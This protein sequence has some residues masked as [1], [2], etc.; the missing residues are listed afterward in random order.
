MFAAPPA[1]T[2]PVATADA[3]PAREMPALKRFLRDNLYQHY[4]VQRMSTK[5]RRIV[6]ELFGA[7]MSDPRLLPS[8]TVAFARGGLRHC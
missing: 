5:G 8:M 3:A 6:T 1:A 7:F 4:Q 2:A